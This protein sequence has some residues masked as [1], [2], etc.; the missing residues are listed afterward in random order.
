MSDVR[1]SMFDMRWIT[2]WMLVCAIALVTS[3]AAH[4]PS[5]SAFAQSDAEHQQFLFAYK[6]LQRGDLAEAASEFDE[7]LGAFPRGEKLGDAQYYRALLHRKNGSNDRAA[8]MLD[9]AAAPTLVPAY[10]VDLLRGQ[11]LSDL[12]RFDDALVALERIDTAELTPQVAVSAFYLRGLAYRGADNLEAAATALA[13]AANLD[14]KTTTRWAAQRAHDQRP[15][16]AVGS[17]R[18]RAASN[19]SQPIGMSVLSLPRR[20]CL[21]DVLS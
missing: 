11:V 8:A 6:L 18:Y 1:S 13:D 7:Y 10:A 17:D 2:R 14:T 9:G 21:G 3:H 15:T 19:Q 4:L 12:R 20:R 5:S 16:R